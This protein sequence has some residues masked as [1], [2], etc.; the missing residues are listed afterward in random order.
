MNP[1][2][3]PH[4]HHDSRGGLTLAEMMI[5]LVIGGL[6]LVITA[7]ASTNVRQW[8]G[9]LGR[10]EK[11]NSQILGL[12]QFAETMLS[13]AVPLVRQDGERS[14]VLFL[15][16]NQAIRFVRAEPGYPSRAGLYQYH[17]FSEQ[18]ADEQWDFI[19]EREL[20]SSTAQFGTPQSPTRLTLYTGTAAPSFAFTGGGGGWQQ[21]WDFKA[22][23]PV[24]VR[25]GMTEWPSLTI[26]L[27]RGTQ[28]TDD[29]TQE[30]PPDEVKP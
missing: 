12:Y 10:A 26:P 17:L 5:A 14:V 24:L 16:S 28:K 3:R 6:A 19:L 13:G 21:D 9:R 4:T 22:T 23:Q 20:L 18:R 7:Q 15:G 1:R 11:D 8:A 27:P 25:F 29:S 2:V 30:K